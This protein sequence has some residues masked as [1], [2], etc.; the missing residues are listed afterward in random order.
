MVDSGP[1]GAVNVLPDAVV[2]QD[3]ADEV[4]DKCSIDRVVFL[5]ACRVCGKRDPSFAQHAGFWY[6]LPHRLDADK[7]HRAFKRFSEST[8]VVEATIDFYEGVWIVKV[9]EV[10]PTCG[11]VTTRV[12][13]SASSDEPQDFIFYQPP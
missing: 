12:T 5:P 13:Y 11:R 7:A 2:V 1:P 4:V 10:S 3:E 9:T 8:G 6:C